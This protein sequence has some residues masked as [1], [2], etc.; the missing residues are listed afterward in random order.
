MIRVLNGKVV[1]NPSSRV[2]AQLHMPLSTGSFHEIY[3]QFLHLEQYRPPSAMMVIASGW[4]L[5]PI[6]E[7][8]IVSSSTQDFWADYAGFAFLVPGNVGEVEAV[9]AVAPPVA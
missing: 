5:V 3:D 9:L 8:E 2:G 4:S 1:L 6:M 7:S